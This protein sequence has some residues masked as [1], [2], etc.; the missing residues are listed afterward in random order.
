MRERTTWNRESIARVAASS[1][2]VAEDPRA[3]NQDHLKQQ[4]AADKYEI[5][6]PSDFAEDVHPS[7]GTWK[8]EYSGGEVKRNEIGMA[9][10]RGDTFNHSEKTAAEQQEEEEQLEKKATVCIRLAKSMLPKT[11]SESMIEDQAVAFMHLPDSALIESIA[12]LASDE[13]EQEQQEGQ[14][15]A[16]QQQQQADEAEQ[17][18]QAQQQQQSDEAEQK[19]QAQQQADEEQQKKQ[20]QQQQQQAEEEKKQAGQIPENFKKKDEG[21]EDEQKKQAAVGRLFKKACDAMAQGNPQAAQQAVQEMTQMSGLQMQSQQQLQDQVMALVQQAM[22]QQQQPAPQQQQGDDQLL[23]QMLQQQEVQASADPTFG[24]IQLDGPNMD[25]GEAKM[26]S[27]DEV[28]NT[29]FASHTEVREASL[30]QSFQTGSPVRTA[31]TRT[32][33]TRPSAGV[34]H[35]GGGVSAPS[36]GSDVDKLAGLWQSA[37]DVKNVFGS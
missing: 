21:E 18:K 14:K 32:V 15:Q 5:G 20:A 8:A 22:S 4:P 35:L 28:L 37:P 16:Q 23:D 11:A 34:A 30:A 36:G 17:K 7:G 9:E 3:M 12:R 26:G 10:M 6:G 29:L 1:S 27:E 19:K 25:V 31:S 24:D 2:K 33:G 13:E